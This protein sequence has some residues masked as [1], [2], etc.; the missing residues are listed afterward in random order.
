MKR[1]PRYT[2][3]NMGPIS[4]KGI[5]NNPKTKRIGFEE[6][7]FAVLEV[8]TLKN[9]YEPPDFFCNVKGRRG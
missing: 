6:I 3:Q 1:F 4:Q 8:E 9:S 5:I 7:H 2:F